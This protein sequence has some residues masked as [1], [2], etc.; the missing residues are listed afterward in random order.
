MSELINSTE[1]KKKV[2]KDIL[3]GINKNTDIKSVHKRFKHFL[4]NVSPEEI[5][6]LEQSFIDEGTPVEEIQELCNVH[7]KV[8]EDS[9]SKQKNRKVLPGH[10]VHTYRQENKVLK[11]L[12]KELKRSSKKAAKGIDPW[13]YLNLL[14]KTAEIETHY[15]R[16]ENQLFP[17][18]EQVNFTGPSRVMWGKHNEIR[19]MFKELR[20]LLEQQNY[21]ALTKKTKELGSSLSSMIFM[22]E[23]ILFP[24]A[25]R[26]LPENTWKIIRRGENK[27]GY[28]WIKPGNIWDPD[29]LPSDNS[30]LK[31]FLDKNLEKT[32]SKSTVNNTGIALSTGNLSAE[33]ID[34]MLKTLPVDISFIDE[35]DE[36]RYY[37]ENN[38][39]LFPR[40]P[41]IIGRK[42]QNCH[43]P[44]SAHIVEKIL[45]SFKK[46][47]KD[48]AE[49]HFSAGD[50][51]IHIRYFPLF[52][53]DGKYKGV[54]EVSQDIS[55]IKH[56]NG[57]RKLL[58]W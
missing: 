41:G 18:L 28:S 25:L 46:H 47:E 35:N 55:A 57:D 10:P 9:L 7:V 34:L 1:E 44:Q 13:K 48:S 11:K 52:D 49:F 45:T 6:Q 29:I 38:D 31:N 56:F 43:P 27:I 54:L 17:Y 53:K 20:E 32:G 24:S 21:P 2:L 26:K 5:A 23:K 50:K 8:F 36:V 16:K 37:S 58:D 30:A 40:S 42:V 51:F 12:I 22:E 15:A 33:Q 14:N 3:N 4:E 19:N 39:R